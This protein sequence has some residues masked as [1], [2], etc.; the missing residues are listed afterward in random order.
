MAIFAALRPLLPQC[1]YL[2]TSVSSY[3]GGCGFE[4]DYLQWLSLCCHSDLI[5]NHVNNIAR[6][7]LS[8]L[9]EIRPDHAVEFMSNIVS[10]VHSCSR[11]L[12]ELDYAA[13]TCEI[14]FL[15]TCL[16]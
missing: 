9:S 15:V 6:G 5:I 1:R 13:V 4:D 16:L 10:F 14:P 12:I 8:S 3:E 2:L 7:D 11:V